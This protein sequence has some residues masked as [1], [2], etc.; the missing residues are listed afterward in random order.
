MITKLEEIWEGMPRDATFFAKL[1]HVTRFY[2]QF[3][4]QK[5]KEHRREELNARA[6]LETAIARLHDDIYDEGKQGEVNKYKGIIEGIEDRKARGATI[7]ARVKWQKV[8][9][10]CTGEFFKSVRQKNAHAVISELGTIKEGV[11]LGK[12]T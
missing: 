11:S 5:A 10:K 12:R 4:K 1:R 8:G 2:R 3:S 6:N 7:R 9:D